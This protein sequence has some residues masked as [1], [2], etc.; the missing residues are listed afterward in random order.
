M[1]KTTTE[2]ASLMDDYTALWN[3]DFSQL[4]AAAEG[5]TVYHEAARGGVVHGRE[6]LEAFVREFHSAFPDFHLAVDD[7][8]SSDEVVMKEWTMTGTHE[9]EFNGISPTGREIES[10][11]MAKVLI[12]DGRVK[13]DRLYYNPQL[14]VEQ[15][16]LTEE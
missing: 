1:S 5:V 9:G 13:E 10:T 14:M 3:G 4:D 16:G 6:A 2:T 11:G 12:A 8:I 7:W 15:L